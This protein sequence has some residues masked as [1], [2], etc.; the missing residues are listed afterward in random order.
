MEAPWEP[1]ESPL[2]AQSR[3][4]S[5]HICQSI[6]Y[7]WAALPLLPAHAE[8]DLHNGSPGHGHIGR[9]I[10]AFPPLFFSLS[11]SSRRDFP[12]ANIPPSFTAPTQCSPPLPAFAWTDGG[13]GPACGT[14]GQRDGACST[15]GAACTDREVLC[16]GQCHANPR[17][18][19]WGFVLRSGSRWWRCGNRGDRP[20][21]A[22]GA[23][24]QSRGQRL[25][26]IHLR[27]PV[28][29]R[30]LPGMDMATVPR[31]LGTGNCG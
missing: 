24:V 8:P 1:L 16:S 13:V 31:V 4:S 9:G 28:D 23:G 22:A 10:N 3:H 6:T 7:T 20:I 14:D 11:L 26:H 5:S 2:G 29:A 25:K 27:D 15:R 18:L 12:R 17:K 19:G 30:L 21:P